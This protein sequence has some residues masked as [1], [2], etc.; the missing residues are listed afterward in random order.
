MW[1]FC[2]LMLT[3]LKNVSCIQRRYECGSSPGIGKYSSR[4]NVMTPERS[5]PSSLC[6]RISSRYRPTGVEPGGKAEDGRPAGGVVLA[7]ERV[8]RLGRRAGRLRRTS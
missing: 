6:R 3:W 7:D 4:L 5:S 2:G 8:R 1:M